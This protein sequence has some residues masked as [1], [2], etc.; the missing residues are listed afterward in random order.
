MKAF[1]RKSEVDVILTC[2]KEDTNI[3]IVKKKNSYQKS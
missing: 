1:I 2:K 3:L